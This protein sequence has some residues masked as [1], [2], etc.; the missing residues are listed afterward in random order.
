MT[1]MQEFVVPKSIPIT[2]AINSSLGLEV[3]TWTPLS[4]RSLSTA[5]AITCLFIVSIYVKAVCKIYP[6]DFARPR[7]LTKVSL[8]QNIVP[9][10]QFQQRINPPQNQLLK[11]PKILQKLSLPGWTV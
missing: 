7:I 2:F 3:L 11:A 10:W 1:A 9:H 6:A 8:W 5:G 4:I